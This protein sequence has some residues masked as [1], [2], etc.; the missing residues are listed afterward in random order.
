M[1]GLQNS[2]QRKYENRP[3][4]S[5][6]D[7]N[8]TYRVRANKSACEDERSCRVRPTRRVSIRLAGAAAARGVLKAA[9]YPARARGPTTAVACAPLRSMT[10]AEN[11]SGA[12]VDSPRWKGFQQ[13]YVAVQVVLSG[14]REG[15]RLNFCRDLF[16]GAILADSE[17]ST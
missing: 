4:C 8:L 7:Y 13:R 11:M 3:W 1:Q 9:G 10:T 12:V 14:R 15:G 5:C 6:Y 2:P 17:V 16:L